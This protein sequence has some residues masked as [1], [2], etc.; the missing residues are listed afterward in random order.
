MMQ[1]QC[2][3]CGHELGGYVITGSIMVADD[4][5][6]VFSGRITRETVNAWF[7]SGELTGWKKPGLRGWFTTTEQFQQDLKRRGRRFDRGNHGD[8]R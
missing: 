7:A 2:G 6:A 5:V 8:A 4:I 1:T 3:N